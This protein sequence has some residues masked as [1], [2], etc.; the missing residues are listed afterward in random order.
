[1]EKAWTSVPA[2]SWAWASSLNWQKRQPAASWA[3]WTGTAGRPNEGIIHLCLC[4]LDHIQSTTFS[5]GHTDT[6]KISINWRKFNI[7]LPRWSRTGTFALWREA[8]GPGLVQS[9]KG[10]RQLW[11]HPAAALFVPMEWSL[12]RQIQALHRSAWQNEKQW[13][14]VRTRE[15]RTAY[16]KLFP[17]STGSQWSRLTRK[18]VQ[19]TWQE[20]F[21]THLNKTL[22]SLYDLVDDLALG[23]ELD[24][25][26]PV[27]SARLN[28]PVILWSK[29]WI[30]KCSVIW[31]HWQIGLLIAEFQEILL[32]C[33]LDMILLIANYIFP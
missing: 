33:D 31:S 28:Y 32:F 11:G 14:C 5:F 29:G 22:C 15:V 16:K 20:V 18:T 13:A 4:L 23:W 25:R 24:D 7:V 9:E 30:L 8:D 17:V 3:V 21:K 1:M 2:E 12:R 10:K 27:V 6:G 19:T 26:P